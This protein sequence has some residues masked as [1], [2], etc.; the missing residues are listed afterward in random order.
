LC[1]VAAD[2]G[3][4]RGGGQSIKSKFSADHANGATYKRFEE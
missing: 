1:R 3:M 2:T 4:A